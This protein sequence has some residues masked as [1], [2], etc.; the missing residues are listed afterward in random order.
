MDFKGFLRHEWWNSHY[1]KYIESKEKEKNS[2][3]A[4]P[5]VSFQANTDW[6]KD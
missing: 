5:T 4:L 2:I 6:H 3:V 1:G